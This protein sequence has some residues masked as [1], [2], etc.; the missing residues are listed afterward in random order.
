MEADHAPCLSAARRWWRPVLC[1]AYVAGWSLVLVETLA[2]L[3]VGLTTLA[4]AS[5]L[6]VTL[7][8]AGAG[9]VSIATW[10]RGAEKRVG[11]ADTVAVGTVTGNGVIEQEMA[12]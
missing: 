8:G 9:P 2:L 7:V 10:S 5:G 3:A 1:W 4:E 12:G 11:V 6:L